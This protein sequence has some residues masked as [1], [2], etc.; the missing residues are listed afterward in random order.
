MGASCGMLTEPYS[1]PIV[2]VNL[3]QGPTLR[4]L[5]GLHPGC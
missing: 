2:T 5:C 1:R 3:F 4:P